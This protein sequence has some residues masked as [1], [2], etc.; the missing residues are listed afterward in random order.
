LIPHM[1][2]PIGGI[3]LSPAVFALSV[4]GVTNLT[5]PDHVTST[6]LKLEVQLSAL[7]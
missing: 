7:K 1:S 6:V 3:S 2:F 4:L 5:F